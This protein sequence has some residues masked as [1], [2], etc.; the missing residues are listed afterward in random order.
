LKIGLEV[1][2]MVK[3]LKYHAQ[4][5]AQSTLD[6]ADNRLKLILCTLISTVLTVFVWVFSDL[7]SIVLE[8]AGSAS[9]VLYSLVPNTLFCLMLVFLVAPVYM[10]TFKTALKMLKG[11]EC[12]VADVFEGFSS[13][14]LY[15][16]YLGLSLVL[17]AALL[18]IVLALRMPWILTYLSYAVNIDQG[19]VK[20]ADVLFIPVALLFVLVSAHP[21]GFVTYSMLD[22]DISVA[23]ALKKART[24]R[25][26]NY[27][28]V[29]ALAFSTLMKL[30]LSMLTLGTVTII[31]TVPMALLTYGAMAQDMETKNEI[32]PERTDI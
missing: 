22:E 13:R 10:G 16:R 8:M 14:K 30:L 12:F 26:G 25:K 29:Y 6:S 17:F 23:A 5:R 28:S 4:K 15:G 2:G 31:H 7:A 3:N 20:L 18:P 32:K 11:E 21:F 19:L 27:R 9:A 1:L 24:A